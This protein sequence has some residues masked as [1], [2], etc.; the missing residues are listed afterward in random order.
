VRRPPISNQCVLPAAASRCSQAGRVASSKLLVASPAG[1]WCGLGS[2][3]LVW[4]CMLAMQ[5]WRAHTAAVAGAAPSKAVS[6]HLVYLAMCNRHR[7]K[8]DRPWWPAL[9]GRKAVVGR[10]KGKVGHGIAC[11]G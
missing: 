2:C 6:G 8:H 10:R 9:A 7:A 3:G 4:Q 1:R 11:G 5:Q